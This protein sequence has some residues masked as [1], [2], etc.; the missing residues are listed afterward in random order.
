MEMVHSR[1]K[2]KASGAGV[3]GVGGQQ[4]AEGPGEG[5]CELR[6]VSRSL[7]GVVCDLF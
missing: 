6:E 7:W 5:P 2:T 1:D 4:R 3:G